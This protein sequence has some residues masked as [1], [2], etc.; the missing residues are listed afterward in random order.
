MQQAQDL[1]FRSFRLDIA[2]ERLWRRSR[3]VP[4]RPKTFAVLR[5]LL[6]HADRLV[7][8]G[9]LLDTVW[10]DTSVS[11]VVPLV[12]IRE[13]RKALGDEAEAPRFIETVPRRGYRFIAPV[14]YA[15]L[16]ES[17]KSKV[18]SP[19]LKSCADSPPPT[20]VLVGREAELG[21]LHK[22]LAKAASGERQIIFITGEAG[23]GKTA[24]IEAFLK[25]ALA[26]QPLWIARGQC[27]EHY[28][29]GEAYLPMLDALGR[30]HR[31]M[32]SVRMVEILRRYAPTWLGQMPSLLQAADLD[33]QQHK[34]QGSSQDRMLR[35]IAEA[36]EVLTGEGAR[37]TPPVLV[38]WLEDLHWSDA[39]TLDL[40][41]FLARRQE[42]ARLLVIGAYRPAEVFCRGNPLPAIKQ[43]LQ[44]HERCE[45]LGL[46]LLG[47]KAVAEY[48]QHRLPRERQQTVSSHL[49]ARKIHQRTGGN[50]LFMVALVSQL[51]TQHETLSAESTPQQVEELLRVIPENLQQ[52]I[53]QQ[54]SRLSLEEQQLL[55]VASVAGVEFSAAT[56]AAELGEEIA[57]SETRCLKLAR[58]GQFLRAC[59]TD[60][61]PDGA[62]AGRY[63]FLHTL[64]RDA[65]YERLTVSQRMRLHRQIGER[66]EA[67]YGAQANAI[68]AELAVHFTQGRDYQRA[69]RYLR[70]A[71]D[72][73]V[74]RYAFQE[75]LGHVTKGLEL[76]HYWPATPERTQQ[77]LLLHMT[78][79][80]PL[81]ALK[82]ESAPE[83]ER[84]YAQIWELHQRLGETVQPFMVV[85]GLWTVH[86][87]RGEHQKAQALA[88]QLMERAQDG[89]DPL[90]LLWAHHAFGVSLFHRGELIAAR[91][92][93]E[94]VEMLYN[95]RQHPRY[96]FD[97]Q[98]A[99]LSFR[100]LLQW[101]MGY[102]EQALQISREAITWGQQFAH[103]Y[104]LAFVFAAAAWLHESCREGAAAQERAETL[105][106]LAR[107]H[108]FAQYERLGVLLR[109]GA[110][111]EQGR[112]EESIA[113]LRQG[114]D[115]LRAA[116]AELGASAW[117]TRLA[118]AYLRTGR[119]EE[120][121]VALTEAAETGQ[122]LGERSYEAELC[123]IKGELA[124]QKFQVSGSKFQVSFPLS[125]PPDARATAEAEACFLQ[126]IDLARRQQAKT[127]ELRA[128]M[129]LSRL[130]RRQ[131]KKEEARQLLAEV[132][133]WFTEGFDT[134][135]LKEAQQLLSELTA[136]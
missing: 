117:L 8:K 48:L 79:L 58:C 92:A 129:S 111:I 36:I 127:F 130:W 84:A 118:T 80:G 133:N 104:S 4:L 56:V 99:G 47:E 134:T 40:L 34:I 121:T 22:W 81:M 12:C 103:P 33:S 131:G 113:L 63:G 13:L 11:D 43:E 49:L 55:E 97:P 2:N 52:M 21:Q 68:A 46:S 39:S 7:T 70:Q 116:G 105:M 107:E 120:G 28:G 54:V 78:V 76:L 16:G 5:Y 106:T 88:E 82:G 125:L 77:E 20:S 75:A 128:A 14:T 108:G 32:G 1:F 50:P 122:R 60:E 38:L 87:V 30:L 119:I 86:I 27:I 19:K 93:L 42:R 71:A 41:S 59:G 29:A 114:I 24:L 73:A 135:D 64:Y 10:P 95:T 91:A 126:A 62:L 18:Q 44:L 23:I 83:V 6:E 94:K 51:L 65:L 115:A 45:E 85:L 90:C 89:Q 15:L 74:R 136:G 31:E 66:K 25:R 124:L 57:C 67:A 26:A 3:E 96:M 109:G 72:N 53:E 9:E 101:S 35:E 100:T 17:P 37:P 123:R 61:W 132:Y 112:Y 102:P 69:V 110:L 98:L